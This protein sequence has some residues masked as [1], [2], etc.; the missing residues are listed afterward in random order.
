MRDANISIY[1]IS[2]FG[3]AGEAIVNQ[4][5]AICPP[6]ELRKGER[7]LNATIDAVTI[8]IESFGETEKAVKKNERSWV[9]GLCKRCK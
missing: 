8:P 6:E 3:L 4:A 1:N 5:E 9:L 7:I 2:P